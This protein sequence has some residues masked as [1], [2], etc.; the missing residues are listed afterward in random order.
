MRLSLDP[1]LLPYPDT[2]PG[3]DPRVHKTIRTSF[4]LVVVDSTSSHIFEATGQSLFFLTRGDSTATPADQVAL[5]AHADSTRWWI[6]RWE[7]E[8]IG[9]VGAGGAHAN[10]AHHTTLWQVL[11]FYLDRLGPR[12]LL[13]QRYP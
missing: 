7:D 4:D 12:P 1:N 11:R 10:P 5:G 8:T 2:R 6:D 9:T 3:H 13:A